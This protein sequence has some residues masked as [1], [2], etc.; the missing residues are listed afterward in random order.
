MNENTKRNN[1][2]ALIIFGTITSLIG[3]E[4]A[5]MAIS[6]WVAMQTDNPMS[7]ALVY[8]IQKFTRIFFSLFT[9][10]IIDA[11]NK[12]KI[13]YLTD[14][15]QCVLNI[16]MLV[17]MVSGLSFDI[18]VI[19]FCAISV[20]QGFCL[21]LF[22]PASRAILPEIIATEKL[23]QI[24]SILEVSRT[25]VS[26]LSVLFAGALVLIFGVVACIL[27]NAVS[28][29]VSGL[30]EVL[31]T[32][33]FH[34]TE[35]TNFKTSKFQSIIDGYKYFLTNRLLVLLAVVAATINFVGTPIFSNILTYQY[36]EIFHSGL[37][38]SHFNFEFLQNEQSFITAIS[39]VMLFAVGIASV[40]GGIFAGKERK[41][42]MILLVIGLV[43][44][45]F[46]VMLVYFVGMTSSPSLMRFEVLVGV[47][48]IVSV[49]YGVAMGAFN[50]YITTL[51][52]R[53]VDRKF[54]GRFFAFNT[55]LMQ[56]TS[57]I[58]MM[59]VSVF[60]SRTNNFNLVYC[61]AFVVSLLLFVVVKAKESL[62]VVLD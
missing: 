6:I 28:F 38:T 56:I 51:Y 14:F 52:Q 12:K 41:V 7:F 42:K 44:V 34:K 40:V 23:Q 59:L 17:V 61:F 32:Y 19:T 31:I 55:I 4:I 18:K 45:S 24:N 48:I 16:V 1:N 58:S 33:K 25:I 15:V 26:T 49:L 9:G 20:I 36:K 50:V 30:S 5:S 21:S 8:S 10:S 2:Q 47:I 62:V 37:L 22:K 29:F 27:I 46:L 54:M 53:I 3:D 13:L 57:P 43:T 11:A 39:T 35:N 60:V